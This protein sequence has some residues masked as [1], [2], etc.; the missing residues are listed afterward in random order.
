[1]LYDLLEN[2]LHFFSDSSCVIVWIFKI[3]WMSSVVKSLS[4]H[5]MDR[6]LMMDHFIPWAFLQSFLYEPYHTEASLRLSKNPSVFC[7]TCLTD[8]ENVWQRAAVK[9]NLM[10]DE[11]LRLSL[12]PSLTSF[13]NIIPREALASIT[14]TFFKYGNDKYP[15]SSY[16]GTWLT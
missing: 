16:T 11:R 1:M 15:T 5:L 3:M 7:Q 9:F 6:W 14:G 12:T 10:S 2:I 13:V 4:F 8:F